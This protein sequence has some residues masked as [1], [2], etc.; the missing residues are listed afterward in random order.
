MGELYQYANRLAHVHFLIEHAGRPAWLVNLCFTDDT[1]RVPTR[2]DE[3]LDE[4]PRIKKRLSF[5][6]AVPHS[7]D[8]FL[9]GL[10]RDAL[11]DAK[12]ATKA[13]A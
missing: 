12:S 6:G 4:L 9:P 1:T 3:W 13:D 7:A 5:T 11:V 10:P 2:I 8:V